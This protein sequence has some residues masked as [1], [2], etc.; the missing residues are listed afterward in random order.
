MGSEI[1]EKFQAALIDLLAY[2]RPSFL[3]EYHGDENE[4]EVAHIR[5]FAD[6]GVLTMDDGVV[7][8]LDNNKAIYLTMQVR[9][10]Y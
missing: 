9:N 4:P 5:T 10:A 3:Q 2:D 7:I 6:A 8:E 1:T